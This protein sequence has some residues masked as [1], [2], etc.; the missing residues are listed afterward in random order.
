MLDELRK[1]LQNEKPSAEN[2]KKAHKLILVLYRHRCAICG[3]YASSVHEIEPRSS[4]LIA[5]RFENM[6]PLCTIHH[7][8]A[9]SRNI[10]ASLILASARL[11]LLYV[12]DTY[13]K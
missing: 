5:W 2:Y 12:K 13:A 4:G 8:L 1:L 11:F 3:G 6:V 9:H 10:K 7:T